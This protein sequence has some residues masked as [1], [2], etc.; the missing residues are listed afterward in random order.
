ML[1][2][3][4]YPVQEYIFSSFFFLAI[5]QVEI[6]LIPPV[7]DTGSLNHWTTREVPKFRV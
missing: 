4:F 7:V 2:F 6:E 5:R 1:C 3:H